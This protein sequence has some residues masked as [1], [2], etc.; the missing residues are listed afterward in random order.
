MQRSSVW[1]VYENPV[2]CP[3]R[4][5][6]S[7]LQLYVSGYHKIIVEILSG[8]VDGRFPKRALHSLMEWYEMYKDNLLEDW[9]LAERHEPLNKIPPFE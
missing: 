5:S 6:L 3:L 1:W 4:P 8:I 9:N 7:E 2:V